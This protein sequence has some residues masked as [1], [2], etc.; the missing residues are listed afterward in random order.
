MMKDRVEVL[1]G[2]RGE[3]RPAV[4]RALLDVG[5]R[6]PDPVGLTPVV[7]AVV[8]WIAEPEQ[9]EVRAERLAALHR[10]CDRTP[11]LLG[12]LLEALPEPPARVDPALLSGSDE[13][14]EDRELPGWRL[15]SELWFTALAELRRLGVGLQVGPG[16]GECS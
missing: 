10:A 3:P 16:A 4:V 7:R 1:V 15:R 8:A 5:G 2:E 11:S 9:A 12:P 13:E 6:R 14:D